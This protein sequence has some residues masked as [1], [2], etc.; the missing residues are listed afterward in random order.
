MLFVNIKSKELKCF[1]FLATQ[2]AH[3]ERSSLLLDVVWEREPQ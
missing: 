3:L 2:T 1:L